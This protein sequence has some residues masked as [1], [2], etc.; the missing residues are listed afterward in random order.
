MPQS[1]EI[2]A[3][4]RQKVVDGHQTGTDYKTVS[5]EFDLHRSIGQIQHFT[6][7]GSGRSTKITPRARRVILQEVT[8]GN[9]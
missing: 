2:S 5:K 6:L 1:K 8:K 7:P 4:L 9:M 3:E